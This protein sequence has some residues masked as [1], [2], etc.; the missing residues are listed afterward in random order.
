MIEDPTYYPAKQLDVLPRPLAS[1]K[2]KYPP[3]ADAANV[4]GQVKLL[5]LIDE[6]GVVQDISVVEAKPE[7]Y[8]FEESAV[9]AFRNARFNPAMRKGRPVKSRGIFVVTFEAGENR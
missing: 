8:G 6:Q 2:P 7:G 1:I 5:I 4:T 3:E 9:D